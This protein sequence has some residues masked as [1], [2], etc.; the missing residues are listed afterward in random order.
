MQVMQA[1]LAGLLRSSL[2]HLNPGAPVLP[3]AAMGISCCVSPC[4]CVIAATNYHTPLTV[5][6]GGH[7]HGRGALLPSSPL[8]KRCSG[9]MMTCSTRGGLSTPSLPLHGVI[10][11]ARPAP[12]SSPDKAA[13]IGIAE[14]LVGKNLLVTGG[15][16]FL[17][18]GD[19]ASCILSHNLN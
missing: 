18:K 12:A 19:G 14:F 11:G 8:R 4:R 9:S 7:A 17:A 2:S 16:G 6:K 3:Y 13:G 5:G 1:T 15:I 10:S